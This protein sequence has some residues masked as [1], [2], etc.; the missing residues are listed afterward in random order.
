MSS[1]P[2]DTSILA[3]ET[4]FDTY[5]IDYRIF[6]DGEYTQ[7]SESKSSIN[8]FKLI[9]GLTQDEIQKKNENSEYPKYFSTISTK[10]FDYIGILTNQ[11]KRDKY[12][13]SIMDNKDEY[14][15]EYKNDIRDGYGIKK[16]NFTEKDDVQ[17][18]Y[19]NLEV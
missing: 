6:K 18:I 8:K 17:E 19:H 13:Y 9:P 16:F 3:N 1:P 11:L 5:E 2:K 7:K 15:G 4:T 14:L 12:G 10:N